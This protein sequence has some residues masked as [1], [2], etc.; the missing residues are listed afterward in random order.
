MKKSIIFF[1]STVMMFLLSVQAM[2]SPLESAVG[3]LYNELPK[4]IENLLPDEVYENI[5]KG[6]N[7]SAAESIS[8]KFI[9]E[10][11][12]SGIS[13]ALKSFL[14]PLFSLIGTIVLA[15]L[16]YYVGTTIGGGGETALG[17]AGG[18]SVTVTTIGILT[19]LWK[20]MS[21]TLFGIGLLIKSAL[22]T[23]TTIYAVSGN[24]SAAAVNSTWLTLLLT[25]LEELCQTVISPLFY[26]CCGFLIV[27]SL[28]KYSGAPDMSGI[29][30]SIKKLLILLL[31]VIAVL[32][33][34]VMSYQTVVAKSADTM[35][36][37]SIKFA[38]GNIIPI[39]GGA[40]GEAA[41]TFLSSV[42]V[43]RG[44]A[45]MITAVSLIIYSLPAVLKILV[46]KFCFT[47]ASIVASVF[48]CKRETEIFNE[49]SSILDIAL[50]LV[51]IC[52]V[53][54]LIIIGIF[55]KNFA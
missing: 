24:V 18:L 9:I 41:D 6:D 29:V 12:I 48:G 32:F 50:A 7:L 28:S 5:E 39:I 49:A 36:L 38:S 4:D 2:G 15:S 26:I 54:F 43:I 10:K 53:I 34:S 46:C 30:T 31:G 47:A 21:D 1:L 11:I 55:A 35:T 20:L 40:L 42:S 16:L 19:P 25:L 3:E 37:R 51:S 14:T 23:M 45:G 8:A 13:E 33:T 27:T 22:P 17:F 52:S 44:T